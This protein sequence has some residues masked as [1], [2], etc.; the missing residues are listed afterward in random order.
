MDIH[1]RTTGIARND[2][3][4]QESTD[5]RP[6]KVAVVAGVW[7]EGVSSG[8]VA[9]A[10]SALEESDCQF[11]IFP[12]A[13]SFDL[14]LITQTLLE[15]TWDGAVV[16]GVIIRGVSSHF[17][18]LCEVVTNGLG[19]VALQ[20]RKPIGFG[21]LM[22]DEEKDALARAGLSHSKEDR[23][24]EAAEWTLATIDLLA[25]IQRD[26]PGSGESARVAV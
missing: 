10:V 11:K 21:V 12:A 17:D 15:G 4:G 14:P 20:A 22:V 23:G 26:M 5:Y 13:S 16:L 6:P 2:G 1:A 24:R 9:G 19:E 8:L 3:S 7:H 25:R 18:R